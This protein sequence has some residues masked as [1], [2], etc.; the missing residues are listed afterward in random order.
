MVDRIGEL[1]NRV[2]GY[3]GYRR[4][5]SMR[6]DDRRLRDEIA[7][8]LQQ[9]VD[10][11]SALGKK[12]ATARQLE[13]ISNVENTISRVRQ[14]ESRVRTAS[15]GYGGLFSDRSVDEH[16]LTQLKAFD[17]AFQASVE[18]LT[19]K[20]SAVAV[21]ES[22]EP[23]KFQ[24]I[25]SVVADLNKL[26]DTRGD[27]IETAVPTKDPDVLQLLEKP[28]EI[29]AQA[30]QLL[31]LRRG[32]TGAILGDNYQFTAHLALRSRN[33]TPV[34]TLVEL[35]GG[36]DWLAAYDNGTSVDLWRVRGA[37]T[38]GGMAQGSSASADLSGP[39]GQQTDVPA[40]YDVSMTGSGD[41]A[42]IRI[43]LAV[44]G[45][46]RAYEG[47]QVPLLDVQIFS[48]GNVS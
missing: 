26:F 8:G 24:E 9:A 33:G 48:E 11:L 16:A 4:K 27:V 41:G 36:P 28:R 5:E 2:P 21:A 45:S 42:Q 44:A 12:L 10:D 19:R 40:T 32:G 37:A 30:R 17:V 34:L 1:L 31:R 14:L 46:N 35:D 43:D 18:E 3:T 38:P 39:Q 7:R 25:D 29:S 23:A 47:S 22:V 13:M 20:I 15:Y 6:D